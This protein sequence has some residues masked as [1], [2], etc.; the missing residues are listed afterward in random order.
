MQRGDRVLG[1]KGLNLSIIILKL[2]VLKNYGNFNPFSPVKIDL[3]PPSNKIKT[4][5]LP[6]IISLI[7]EI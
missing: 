5:S 2:R 6:V 4:L 1:R 3:F 7:D